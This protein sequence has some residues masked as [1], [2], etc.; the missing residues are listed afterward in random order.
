MNKCINR[1]MDIE[2]DV[3]CHFVPSSLQNLKLVLVHWG[4]DQ[5]PYNSCDDKMAKGSCHHNYRWQSGA[6]EYWEYVLH[7]LPP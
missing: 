3:M 7:P 5:G 4:G 6:G 1:S 2:T